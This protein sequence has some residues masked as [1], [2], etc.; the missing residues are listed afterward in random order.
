MADQTTA[1]LSEDAVALYLDLSPDELV[2]LEVAA[3]T[4][5]EWALAIKA[6]ADAIDPSYEYRVSLIAAAPGSSKWLARIERMRAAVDDSSVN[7]ALVRWKKGW[8]RLPLAL[9]VAIGLGVVIPTS[10][11]PTYEYWFDSEDFNET[12][13]KQIEDTLKKVV[14]DPRVKARKQGIY[15]EVQRDPR[16]TGVGGGAPDSVEWK[17]KQTVPANQFAIEDGLFEPEAAPPF[18]RIVPMTLDVILV[19]PRLENAP[20]AWTF[21]QEGIPGTFNAIMKDKRFL[22][23]LDRSAVRESFRSNIPMRIRLEVKQ[24]QIDGEWKVTR[25][26]RVVVEVIAPQTGG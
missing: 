12:Q 9:R 13:L 23:A 26:G 15:S 6:A 22:A 5:I 7:Q 8:D 20:R 11:V 2:D 16:I 4:A 3:S 10:A 1:D 19:T 21:R 17:P 25:K 14:D 24:R 18:E